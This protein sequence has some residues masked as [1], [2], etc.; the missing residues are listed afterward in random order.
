MLP[1]L[2]V[3]PAGVENVATRPIVERELRKLGYFSEER[4]FLRERGEQSF[5]QLLSGSSNESVSAA[6][7]ANHASQLW[8]WD[9]LTAKAAFCACD[10]D[11]SG[12]IACH[13]Y[14]LL[15]ASIVH[16]GTSPLDL[17]NTT[18]AD[19][20]GRTMFTYYHMKHE[21]SSADL[22]AGWL[23]EPF[24]ITL[25]LSA[26]TA[27]LRDLCAADS[28]VVPMLRALQWDTPESD[29]DGRPLT[30]AQFRHDAAAKFVEP[31]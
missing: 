4:A 29:D 1:P 18:L 30:Y 7:F 24:D 26:R 11:N 17:T 22:A 12:G 13:E 14:L 19:V 8:G 3:Q 10:L 27:L 20:R 31:Y 16:Y 15:L 6:V 2:E 25:G 21:A 5:W 9:Q 28:H 23:P